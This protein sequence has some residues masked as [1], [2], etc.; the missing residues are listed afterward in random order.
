MTER[1][2]GI[3]TYR[4]LRDK[5]HLVY[6]YA[7]EINGRP[8]LRI[9]VGVFRTRD[10]A[11]VFGHEFS[12]REH[13]DH[14]VAPAPIRFAAADGGD[15]VVTPSGLWTRQGS[16]FREVFAFDDPPPRGFAAPGGIRLVPSP[17]NDAVAFQ[18]G[19]RVF[20]VRLGADKA[21]KLTADGSNFGD[22]H[23]Y[24]PTPYWSPSGRYIA[25]HD[26]LEFEFN[27]SLWVARPDGSALRALVDYRRPDVSL[28]VKA[29]VWHPTDD[30]I[31]FV[32]S[33]S[34]GTV[35]VGG[36]IR[37]VDMAGKIETVLAHD[38][39]AGQEFA[40]PLR[41]EDGYLHY[42]RV[43]FDANYIERIFFDERVPLPDLQP[44]Q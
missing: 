36:S 16:D 4:A 14:F 18:Y 33:Y 9:A 31:L 3:A 39:E 32:E 23:D 6:H 13:M 41:I 7:A 21:V 10:E 15:F 19:V 28:A 11:A 40:G 25:F 22:E 24:G 35:S 17:D 12:A 2:E 5:G 42:R 27:T 34:M 30:R 38:R 37:S 43:Q 1:A 29:F 8:W 26:F 44:E 20:A